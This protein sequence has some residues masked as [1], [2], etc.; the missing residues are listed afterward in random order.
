MSAHTRFDEY[1]ISTDPALLDIAVIHDF[2][3]QS[4][5]R[6]VSRAR[7]LNGPYAIPCASDCTAGPS[8]SVSPE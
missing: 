3:A 8:K 5:G 2:L 4:Y 7:S 1:A 6:R